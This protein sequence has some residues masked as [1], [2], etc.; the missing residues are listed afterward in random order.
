M[1]VPRGPKHVA[2]KIKFNASIAW[3]YNHVCCVDVN[4]TL[5]YDYDIQQDAHYENVLIGLFD[6]KVI[7]QRN[8]KIAI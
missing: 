8:N 1:M 3:L 4:L 6:D 7:Q 2:V 5:P